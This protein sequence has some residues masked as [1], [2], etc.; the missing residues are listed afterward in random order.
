MIYIFK[1]WIYFNNLN[2]YL[3]LKHKYIYVVGRC[4][5]IITLFIL[6]VTMMEPENPHT[7]SAQ[8]YAESSESNKLL[9]L[10]RSLSRTLWN[11]HIKRWI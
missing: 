6:Y 3:K 2:I 10:I 8:N 7:G 9:K 5:E 11:K 1:G 4:S